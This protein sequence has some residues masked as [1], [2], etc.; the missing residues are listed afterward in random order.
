M[1]MERAIDMILVTAAAMVL[2]H[3]DRPWKP[4]DTRPPSGEP[5]SEQQR[6]RST[7]KPEGW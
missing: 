2:D 6:F 4:G 1:I 3:Q 7:S 5:V